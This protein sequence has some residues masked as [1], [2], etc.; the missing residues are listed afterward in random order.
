MSAVRKGSSMSDYWQY[1]WGLLAVPFG[2]IW[3]GLTG[4]Q[5]TMGDHETAIAILSNSSQEARV[6]R[7][8]IYEKIEIVR[9]ESTAQHQAL[10]GEL[11]K[12][13]DKARDEQRGDHR[14]ARAGLDA[15][16]SVVK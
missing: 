15:A 13:H 10:R 5:K 1:A 14:L 9:T 16:A 8:A 7:A 4:V 3:K 2:V 12:Q 11:T 6:S